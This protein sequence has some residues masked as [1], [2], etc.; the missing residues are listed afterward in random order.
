MGES[1]RWL[2]VLTL[3]RCTRIW[4]A[5]CH[6]IKICNASI[7]FARMATVVED[8]VAILA[9]TSTTA[10]A[11]TGAMLNGPL[12]IHGQYV[13]LP[14][15]LANYVKMIF[16]VILMLCVQSRKLILKAVREFVLKSCPFLMVSGLNIL[17]YAVMVTELTKAN[18]LVYLMY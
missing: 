2:T 9:P 18:A 4:K 11:A 14:R 8:M 16:S 10:V 7:N 13:P 6:A 1:R 17:F 5:V 15:R 3:I 12:V